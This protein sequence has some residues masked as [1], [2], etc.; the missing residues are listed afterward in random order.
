VLD[1][2]SF[3]MLLAALVGWVDQRQQEA[4]AY[5]IEENR[6]LRSHLCGRIRLTDGERRR[7]ARHGHRLGRRRLGEVATRALICYRDAK[8]SAP[9]RTRLAEAGIR[10]VRTPYQVPNANAYAEQFVRS[11]KQECLSRMIPLGERHLC[12]T[13]AE[14]VEHSRAS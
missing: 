2:F 9:V 6:I 4:V 13:L 5:V 7:L 8:W 1:A 12:R 11:I 10:V 14:Y 3:R